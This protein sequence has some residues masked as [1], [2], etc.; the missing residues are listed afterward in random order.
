MPGNKRNFFFC[1]GGRERED[2]I[3]LFEK[4]KEGDVWN[5]KNNFSFI[6]EG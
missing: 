5:K 1:A 2:E 3:R 4:V 6:L